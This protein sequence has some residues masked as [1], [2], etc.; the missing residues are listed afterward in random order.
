MTA[1]TDADRIALVRCYNC[2]DD[3]QDTD[4]G[5]PALDRLVTLGWL[6]K[7]GRGRWQIAPEGEAVINE[8]TGLRAAAKAA[9][10]G[11]ST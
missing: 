6:D 3:G 10:D 2:F 7:I 4:V 9:L 5:R 11:E 1:T 8:I